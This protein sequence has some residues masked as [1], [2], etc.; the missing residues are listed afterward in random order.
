[1]PIECHLWLIKFSAEKKALIEPIKF[2]YYP[3]QCFGVEQSGVNP[4]NNLLHAAVPFKMTCLPADTALRIFL[5][6]IKSSYNLV[7]LPETEVKGVLSYVS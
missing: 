5:L 6:K 7:R 3:D 4:V 2:A 1:M